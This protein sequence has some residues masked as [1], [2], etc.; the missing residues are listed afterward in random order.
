MVKKMQSEKKELDTKINDLKHDLNR[1]KRIA[2]QQMQNQ[3]NV[4]KSLREKIACL[5][6]KLL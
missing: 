2:K 5:E 3:D 6:A 4:I 1:Q